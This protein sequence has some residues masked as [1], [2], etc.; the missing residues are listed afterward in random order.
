MNIKSAT[1]ELSADT[2]DYDIICLT[3]THLDHTIFDHQIFHYQNKIIF[4][5]DQDVHGGGGLL[6]INDVISVEQVSCNNASNIE[7]LLIR[8]YQSLV[9]EC[10]YRPPTA[11]DLGPL[12]GVLEEVTMKYPNDHLLLVGDM[13]MPGID[14]NGPRIKPLSH[15]KTFYLEFLS[16]LA[17]YNLDQLTTGPTH[18]HGNTLDLI[19]SNRPYQV[20]DANVIRPGLSDHFILTAKISSRANKNRSKC[21]FKAYNEVDLGSFQYTLQ[22]IK[23]KLRF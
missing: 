23:H 15:N 5:K 7:I 16:I 11:R 4:R 6:A 19:C 2:H 9:I 1:E 10:Y 3:E 18:I 22:E 14:W 20:V 8:I 21:T 17:Q 12:H 13:N